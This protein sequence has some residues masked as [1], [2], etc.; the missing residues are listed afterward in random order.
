[1]EKSRPWAWKQY[2]ERQ[3][4]NCPVADP[5]EFFERYAAKANQND[6]GS[7]DVYSRKQTHESSIKVPEIPDKNL[8]EQK[9]SKRRKRQDDCSAKIRE[10]IDSRTTDRLGSYPE[11]FHWIAPHRPGIPFLPKER[12]IESESS[13]STEEYAHLEKVQRHEMKPLEYQGTLW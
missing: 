4:G 9:D 8:H 5:L 1:M 10:S 7:H 13:G 2:F 11:G 3:L 6:M 12:R